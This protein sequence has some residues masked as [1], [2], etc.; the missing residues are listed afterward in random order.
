MSS[1]G[2]GKIG[3]NS[4]LRPRDKIFLK[5]ASKNDS[6]SNSIKDTLQISHEGIKLEEIFNKISY[7]RSEIDKEPEIAKEIHEFPKEKIAS[8][9]QSSSNEDESNFVKTL[10]AIK[11]NS[12]SAVTAHSLNANSVLSLIENI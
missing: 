12:E 2:I 4:P 1:S 10:E 11:N 8:Y 9:L 5:N 3:D 6:R 7:I